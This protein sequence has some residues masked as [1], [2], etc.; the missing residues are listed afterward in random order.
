MP[1]ASPSAMT[2]R[3]YEEKGYLIGR[4]ES[5]NPRSRRTNDLF[6]FADHVVIL[7]DGVLFV[8]STTG[9][10]HAARRKKI[11][12]SPEAQKI[13]EIGHKVV[14]VSWSKKP[15]PETGH[16]KWTPRI[17]SITPEMFSK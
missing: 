10:N 3:H 11:L 12:A 1:K 17:E 9:S 6:G 8:Q 7:W 13:I 4:V 5:Y 16:L 15:S 2:K 14:I